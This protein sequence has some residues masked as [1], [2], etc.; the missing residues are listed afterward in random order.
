MFAYILQFSCDFIR[1]ESTY[2]LYLFETCMCLIKKLQWS[3]LLVIKK[4][5]LNIK[6]MFN[7]CFIFRVEPALVVWSLIL[8]LLGRAC[9]IFPLAILCNKFREHKITKKMMFIMWF[10]GKDFLISINILF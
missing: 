4:V 2:I 8:C 9:N 6:T 5:C 7:F 3:L 10:S 1:Q